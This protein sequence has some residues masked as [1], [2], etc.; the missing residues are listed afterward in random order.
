MNGSGDNDVDEIVDVKL[1]FPKNYKVVMLNDDHTSFD[2]VI[3][4]LSL[5]FDKTASQGKDIAK[6]IHEKGSAVV[7]IYPF[8]IAETKIVETHNLA[9]QNGFPLKCIY[10]EEG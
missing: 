10:E 9:K 7:G 4:V 6:E 2:F 3:E 5:I 8:P 1:K